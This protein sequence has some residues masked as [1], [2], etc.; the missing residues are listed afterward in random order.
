[1]VVKERSFY[2]LCGGAHDNKTMCGTKEL[3]FLYKAFGGTVIVSAGVTEK[4]LK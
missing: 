3:T 2:A 4:G 1:M